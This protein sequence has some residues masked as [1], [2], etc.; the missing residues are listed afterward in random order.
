MIGLHRGA[1][2]AAIQARAADAAPTPS[3]LAGLV[4]AA[5]SARRWAQAA[6]AAKRLSEMAPAT[7][8]DGPLVANAAGGG[9]RHPLD[10]EDAFGPISLGTGRMT[11]LLVSLQP[12]PGGAD[13]SV[14]DLS[15]MPPYRPLPGITDSLRWCASWS[16]TR[17]LVLAGRGRE[18]LRGFPREFDDQRG[19]GVCADTSPLEDVVRLE[20]GD[21]A[22]VH[23]SAD[24]SA[25]EDAR[26]DLWRYAGD[27]TRAERGARSWMRALPRD[28]LARSRLGEI[29]YHRGHPSD[30]AETFAIVARA[31]RNRTGV[32]SDGEAD[33]LLR[34]GAA[35]IAAG[36]RDDG[37]AA[38]QQ[39]DDT[40]TRALG[41]ETRAT[42]PREE[43]VGH[44]TQIS[45]FARLQAGDALREAGRLA[46]A[47]E[48]YRAAGE[49]W[50]A[51]RGPLT[52]VQFA[53]LDLNRA[54]TLIALGRPHEALASAT[55]AARTEPLNPAFL[56][57]Q[58]YAAHRAGQDAL[59]ER[60]DRAALRADPSTYP[61]ANDLGVLL[62]RRGHEAA[63]TAMLRRAVGANGNYALGWFNLGVVLGRRGPGHLLAAQGALAR[64][65]ALDGS[66]A[67]RRR[68]LTI[69][70]RTYRTGLDLAAPL[71]A[72]WRFAD[73]ARQAP[74]K[75]VALASLLLLGLGLGRAATRSG[76]RG[77]GL[78]SDLLE[79]LTALAGRIALLRGPWPAGV[80]VAATLAVFLLPLT[81]DPQGGLWATAA[82]GLGVLVLV[83]AATLARTAAARR[84]HTNVVH[85]AWPPGVLIG[86]G[87]SAVG[88]P[89]APLP[90]TRETPESASV[91]RAAPLALALLG[92]ALTLLGAWLHVP[93][94]RA[95]AVVALVIAA[96]LLTPVKPIDGG[97][98]G[99]K[100]GAAAGLGALALAALAV[101]GIL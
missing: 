2:A 15:F 43:V 29:Q 26:Q 71:P 38:L 65:V 80:A 40:A 18:A 8:V 91:H 68:V 69:D 101:A 4:V 100:G 5:E 37:I 46:A 55:A 59:S 76:G 27:L 16:H 58:A 34:R 21:S 78:A 56:M 44:L 52:T 66:F 84:A 72:G 41:L 24:L 86:L 79:S 48:S 81:L 57:T 35:L 51:L 7:V 25:A 28:L 13:A 32:W 90:V 39:A 64:A 17:D 75:T 30:A 19:T 42:T 50:P 1:E 96:S 87:V 83:G 98:V 63:A 60:L 54:I 61:A 77:R 10:V 3:M 73:A 97:L 99:S 6:G 85:S 67:D 82:F 74:A 9:F 92:L 36:R 20:A 95:L 94:T 14:T 62:A 93:L 53:A 33:A 47:L 23:S 22:G 12:S 31:A 11:P 88:V 49:R 45:Y 70:A 89:W